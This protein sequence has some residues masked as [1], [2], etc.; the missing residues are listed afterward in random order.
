MEVKS[1]TLVKGRT[2]EEK[3]AETIMVFNLKD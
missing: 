2:R 1:Q 3:L